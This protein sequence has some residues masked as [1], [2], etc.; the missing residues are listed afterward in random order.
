MAAAFNAFDVFTEDLASKVHNLDTDVL[1]LL[2]TNTAP[3][4]ALDEVKADLTEISAGFGYSAGGTV[5]ANNV[6]SQSGGVAK[7]VGDAVVFTAAG[8]SI[9]PFR[10]VV[11]YNSTPVA[12]PLIGWWDYGSPLTLTAGQT[13][14]VGKDSSGGNWDSGT[15]ILNLSF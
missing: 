3:D 4:A 6:I 13:L 15:P 10:Y 14:A 7:L 5:L 11:L 2:L 1:K 12:G 8:G 9:G